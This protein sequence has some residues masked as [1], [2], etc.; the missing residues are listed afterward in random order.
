MRARAQQQ[1]GKRERGQV[2]AGIERLLKILLVAPIQITLMR[3]GGQDIGF[4]TVGLKGWDL[5]VPVTRRDETGIEVGLS[6]AFM[7]TQVD[8]H[9]VSD[10]ALVRQ[11]EARILIDFLGEA[12][13]PLPDS[14]PICGDVLVSCGGLRRCIW[15]GCEPCD[16]AGRPPQ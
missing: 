11:V 6:E 8:L 12:M 1:G 2:V 16:D 9:D 4:A 7:K 10:Q 5:I 3:R 15:N 13:R 14:C